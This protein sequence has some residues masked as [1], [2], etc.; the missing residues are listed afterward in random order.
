[1]PPGTTAS[2]NYVCEDDKGFA[3]L[4]DGNESTMCVGSEGTAKGT[5]TIELR[6]HKPLPGILGIKTRPSAPHHNNV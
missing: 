2:G 5:L 3:N 1:M 6:F 4:I